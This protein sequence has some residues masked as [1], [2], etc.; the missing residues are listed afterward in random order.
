MAKKNLEALVEYIIY[1]HSDT[2]DLASTPVEDIHTRVLI[3][4]FR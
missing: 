4:C 3:H 1:E 2:Y